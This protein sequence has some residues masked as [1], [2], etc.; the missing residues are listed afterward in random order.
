[1]KLLISGCE[2]LIDDEDY[3][4][5][6]RYSWYVKKDKYGNNAY[7]CTAAYVNKK[8]Y[9]LSMHRL[10]MGMR[11]CE[12]DHADRNG[13]NNQKSNLRYCTSD[14]NSYSRRKSNKLGFKGVKQYGV[15]SFHAILHVNKKMLKQGPFRTAEDA[16]RAYDSMAMEHHGSF[17]VLNFGH[18]E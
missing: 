14:Q 5:L 9:K 15:N 7:V 2:V 1:M 6:S 3:P 16:A 13:L 12:L 18:R 10:I 17:A 4:L 11:Q 8:P